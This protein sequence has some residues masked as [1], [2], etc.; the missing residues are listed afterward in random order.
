MLLNQSAKLSEQAIC[1]GQVLL[2]DMD[3]KINACAKTALYD[4]ILQHSQVVQSVIANGCRK[5]YIDG[6]SGKQVI[7]KL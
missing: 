1:C 6:H 2:R 5:V 3:I 7:P 4:W